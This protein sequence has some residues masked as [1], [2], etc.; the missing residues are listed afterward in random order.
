MSTVQGRLAEHAESITDNKVATGDVAL[1][2][3]IKLKEAA[4]AGAALK[5]S[6]AKF[7]NS[8]GMAVRK[9]EIKL[10]E[11]QRTGL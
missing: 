3:T 6:A 11:L 8:T 9:L 1:Q 2:T 10:I 7:E 4:S 5:E